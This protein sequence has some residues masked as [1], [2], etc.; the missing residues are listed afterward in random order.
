MLWLQSIYQ[1]Q[2]RAHNFCAIRYGVL[3]ALNPALMFSNLQWIITSLQ[4]MEK[5]AY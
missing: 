2:D 4:V 5:V 1:I 3:K